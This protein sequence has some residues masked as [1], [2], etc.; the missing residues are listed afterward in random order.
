MIKKLLISKLIF[1][2]PFLVVSSQYKGNKC[3]VGSEF[4]LSVADVTF[5]SCHASTIIQNG[6][7]LISAWFGGTAE[8]N[9]DVGIW[10]SKCTDGS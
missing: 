6:K 7:E 3:I 5:P 2:I 9:P 4:I 1:L 8:R 10:V